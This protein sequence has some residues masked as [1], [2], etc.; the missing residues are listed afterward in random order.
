MKAPKTLRRPENW[1]DFESLCKKLWGEIWNC[2]EIKKNGRNGQN[3]QG[4]DI[5]GVPLGET[6]YWGIQCKGK[7]EYSNKQFTEEEIRTEVEKASFFE[8]A[9]KKIYLTTTAEKDAIIETFV[10]K[11]NTENRQKGKFEIHLFSWE[12]I[13]E[14]IDENK[15]TYDWYVKSQNF[16]SQRNVTLTFHDG[17]IVLA[18]TPQFKLRKTV[19]EE[20]VDPERPFSGGFRFGGRML[21][22]LGNLNN[23]SEKVNLSYIPFGLTVHNKGAEAIEEYKVFLSFKGEVQSI[24][25]TNINAEG[26]MLGPERLYTSNNVILYSDKMSAVLAPSKSVLVGDDSYSSNEIFLKSAPKASKVIVHWKLISKNYKNEG[27]L[28]LDITPSIKTVYKI[29]PLKD[30]P[31]NANEEEIIEDYIVLN[32]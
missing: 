14:L 11:L 21:D 19:Y 27:E 23:W 29:L 6:A 9:L 30:R 13:V 26:S 3:Q 22:M 2:P 31:I 25:S 24:S 12:D 20:N 17:S 8:P 18:C 28:I 32:Q 7:S 4:V 15:N 16:K 1:Q 5:Y 10:R